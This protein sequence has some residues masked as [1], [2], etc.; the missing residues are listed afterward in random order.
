MSSGNIISG[1]TWARTTTTLTITSTAHGLLT[2]DY[3]V[4]RN[5]NVDYVYVEIIVTDSDTF[6]AQVAD[7]GGTSGTTGVYIPAL[8][9]SALNETTITVEAPN[10]GN[11]QLMSMR[12]YINSSETGTFTVSLPTALDNGAGEN[13]ALNALNPPLFRA[14]DVA[15]TNSSLIGGGSVGWVNASG[16]GTYTLSGSLDTF[17]AVILLFQF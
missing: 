4:L 17:G 1:L 16:Y 10:S 3:V 6:T 14:Y 9:V 11:V 5:F 15:G 2:G 13:T 8:D 7:S 12:V